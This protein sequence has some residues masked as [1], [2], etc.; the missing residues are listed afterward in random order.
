[1]VN[2]LSGV[3]GTGNGPGVGRLDMV[4][5][6]TGGSGFI[7]SHIV[8]K[9]IEHSYDV[10]VMDLREPHR[11]DVEWLRGNILNPHDCLAACRDVDV[12]YH[13]AAVADVNV[14]LSDPELCVRVNEL[15][16][17]NMLKAA[18]ATEVDRFILIKIALGG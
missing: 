14:A 12:V 6:V 7:G 9:L 2:L 10:R 4:V 15:G 11:G 8:D 17:L 13:L 3:P 1:M 16:T 18:V 5:L